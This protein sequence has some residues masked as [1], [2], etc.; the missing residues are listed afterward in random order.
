M[1]ATPP[2]NWESNWARAEMIILKARFT[3]RL[4]LAAKKEMKAEMTNA[5]KNG[6]QI[7]WSERII[8]RRIRINMVWECGLSECGVGYGTV[9]GTCEQGNEISCSISGVE[10]PDQRRI[11]FQDCVHRREY[12]SVYFVYAFCERKAQA[13]SDE[14]LRRFPSPHHRNTV[15]PGRMSICH[16][17]IFVTVWSTT[18]RYQPR[19]D[20]DEGSTTAHGRED[21][22][23]RPKMKKKKLEYRHGERHI[24]IFCTQSLPPSASAAIW[25]YRSSEHISVVGPWNNIDYENKFHFVIRT[26]VRWHNQVAQHSR[27]VPQYCSIF[28]GKHRPAPLFDER[29][30][31][32]SAS[33]FVLDKRSQIPDC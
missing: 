20:N 27:M 6:S 14:S 24:R 26:Y 19:T 17:A 1:E 15:L 11:T 8:L 32:S 21:L 9:A 18:G 4:R 16:T 33:R 10:F 2:K 13:A 22:L 5:N 12:S 30:A 23:N 7:H 28:Q 3:P 29:G 31:R 25:G